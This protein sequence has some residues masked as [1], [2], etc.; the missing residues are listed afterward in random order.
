MV[1]GFQGKPF[2]KKIVNIF[3]NFKIFFKVLLPDDP[4]QNLD[5][6]TF[7]IPSRRRRFQA[8][9]GPIPAP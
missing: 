5:R 3:Q 7:K 6:L 8:V 9:S 2:K 4:S 1:A